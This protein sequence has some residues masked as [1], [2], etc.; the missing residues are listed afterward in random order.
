MNPWKTLNIEPTDDKKLIKKAYAVLIKQYKPDEHPEKFQE[1]QEAY[2]LALEIPQNN[3]QTAFTISKDK[4]P[5]NNGTK[6]ELEIA[7][8]ILQQIKSVAES[9]LVNRF[10]LNH[11][12]FIKNFK[13][14]DDLVLKEETAQ[15]AFKLVSDIAIACKNKNKE[16]LIP[17]KIIKYMHPVFGWDER[18]SSYLTRFP[19]EHVSFMY[20]QTKTDEA[21]YKITQ[22]GFGGRLKCLF[23]DIMLSL[24]IAFIWMLF[25]DYDSF[26]F[27][28]IKHAFLIFSFHRL[29]F[30][31]L[32]KVSFGKI[33]N[34]AY[35]VSTNGSNISRIKMIIKH[36]IINLTLFPI[37]AW[38]FD[39]FLNDKIFFLNEYIEYKIWFPIFI[40]LIVINLICLIFTKRFFHEVVTGI[41]V[42]QKV[43]EEEPL[44]DIL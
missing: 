14:I 32:F 31:I 19:L 6:E 7:E 30:D 28:F 40:L 27:E 43:P 41:K 10:D 29:V 9:N 15:K 39:R 44:F 23:T 42:L 8:T 11:W 2:K 17:M 26:V 13:N 1:I 21:P 16:L 3:K 34:H 38:L 36:I 24:I 5:Q 25:I 20:S 33:G 18:Y 22:L 37:Y 4:L 12:S 35:Y